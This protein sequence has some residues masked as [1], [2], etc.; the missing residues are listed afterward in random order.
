MPLDRAEGGDAERL[1]LDAVHGVVGVPRAAD[2]TVDV[3]A[4][5]LAAE[6]LGGD[7]LRAE[8]QARVVGI[9]AGRKRR[10]EDPRQTPVAAIAGLQDVPVGL[11][12]DV[13]ERR[14]A[15]VVPRERVAVLQAT[16]HAV[17][18]VRERGPAVVEEPDALEE[19]VEPVD[20][21]VHEAAAAPV[22]RDADA[23]AEARQE[24]VAHAQLRALVLAVD[25]EATV[26]R[27]VAGDVLLP[28]EVVATVDV[29]VDR[30]RAVPR[31]VRRDG[32]QGHARLREDPVVTHLDRTTRAERA[33]GDVVHAGARQAGLAHPRRRGHLAG[34]VGR[35]LRARQARG[36]LAG[37]GRP[38]RRQPDGAG[39]EATPGAFL[40]LGVSSRPRK[41]GE[42]GDRSAKESHRSAPLPGRA[43]D[44][45][46]P[47]G[48]AA[49]RGARTRA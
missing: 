14:A 45:T 47:R 36:G 48:R 13:A 25:D 9:A 5:Q 30:P 46:R 32:G 6:V 39:V 15:L 20:R 49:G 35:R 3:E 27:V 29:E 24:A 1:V 43:A 33:G 19:L 18:V 40:G 38:V 7:E 44:P 4:A 12:V 11:E 42:H 26:R 22:H 41:D 31:C 8:V 2:A 10:A 28:A 34:V 21:G 23:E 37:R 16:V 17:L